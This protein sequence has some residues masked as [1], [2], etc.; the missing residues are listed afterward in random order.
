[1]LIKE[2]IKIF[3]FCVYFVELALENV[4]NLKY[5]AE[6]CTENFGGRDTSLT[7]KGLIKRVIVL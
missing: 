4:S 3:Y 7:L 1:M 6:F 2:K 5:A